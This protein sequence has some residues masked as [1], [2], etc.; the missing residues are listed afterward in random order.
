MTITFALLRSPQKG[1]SMRNIFTR[2]LRSDRGKIGVMSTQHVTFQFASRSDAPV[3]ASLSRDLIEEGLGWQ[4]RT[5]RIRELIGDTETIALVGR[6][7][8]STIGFSIMTFG[9]ERA[10]LVLLAVR[11]AYQRRGIA[12]RMTQ[13]LVESAATAGIA[14][15][16]VELRVRNKAAYEFYRSIGFAETL[17]LAGYYRGRETAIRMMRMLRAPRIALEPWRPPART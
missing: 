12:R 7:G 13:W 6:G 17:R 3:I 15:I 4:Y 5:E 11:P 9:D 10:H 14:S 1:G 16:H 8:E 2:H